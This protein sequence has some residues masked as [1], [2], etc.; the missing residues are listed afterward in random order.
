MRSLFTD[1]RSKSPKELTVCQ[2]EKISL[3]LGQLAGA[4]HVRCSEPA[5]PTKGLAGT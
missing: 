2:G 1:P 4:A 3:V 5:M